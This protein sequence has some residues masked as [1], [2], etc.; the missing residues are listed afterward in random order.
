MNR[1][2]L[3]LIFIGMVFFHTTPSFCSP[4]PD[5][6]GL[7][8]GL[9]KEK[10]LKKFSERMIRTYR[11]QG[12][13]QHIT[14]NYVD[15]DTLE[16]LTVSL[17]DKKVY[18]WALDDR[19]EVIKQYLEEFASGN[20][21]GNPKTRIALQSALSDL[22]KEIFI[23]ITNRNRPIIFTDYYTVGIAKYAS[24]LEFRMREEDPPTFEDG[25]FMIRLGDALNEADHPDAIKGIVAHE[26]AHHVLEH[27]R[28]GEF[29]CEFEREAN[30]LIKT[31]G[32]EDELAQASKLFGAKKKGDSPCSDKV[33]E[34]Q[35]KATSDS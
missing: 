21:L 15:G 4:L 6:K 33:F 32:F 19:Q 11:N 27:L 34:E 8:I 23:E 31:W 35:E 3:K 29:S 2:I 5:I 17:K 24:S 14:F 25:F 30:Q 12:D 26:I 20:L 18:S 13:Q 10:L 16:L 7:K 1:S 28:A 22:P 9:T